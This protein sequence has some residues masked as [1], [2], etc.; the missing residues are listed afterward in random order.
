MFTHTHEFKWAGGINDIL[1]IGDDESRHFLL[2]A[3]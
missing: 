2:A 1:A 3:N